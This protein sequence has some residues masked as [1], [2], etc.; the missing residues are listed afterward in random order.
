MF[1][2]I[3]YK[4]HCVFVKAQVWN[5][6]KKMNLMADK[7]VLH[8]L[9]KCTCILKITKIITTVVNDFNIM[10]VTSCWY[11]CMHVYLET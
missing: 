7:K 8:Y 2:S 5:G 6:N 3:K 4:A 11:K 1:E 9:Y 10:S